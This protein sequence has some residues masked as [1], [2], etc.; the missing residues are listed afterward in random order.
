M[1]TLTGL[2]AVAWVQKINLLDKV[3]MGLFGWFFSGCWGAVKLFFTLA[4]ARNARAIG[5]DEQY[6]LFSLIIVF[7]CG[8]I[9]KKINA[10]DAFID[11]AKEGFPNRHHHHPLPGRHVGG[12]WR[13]P[14]Q[15]RTGFAGRWRTGYRAFFQDGRPLCRCLADGT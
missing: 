7:I 10:Y 8:A 9:Y 3:V 12:D 13:V 2:L 14:G 5:L 4:A 15:R 11:G 6:H 1:S